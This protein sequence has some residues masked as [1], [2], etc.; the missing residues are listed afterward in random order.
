MDADAEQLNRPA[1]LGSLENPRFFAAPKEM[2]EW[3]EAS[4]HA[5]DDQWVGYW[6][7][8]SGLPSVT[9]PESVDVALCF[10]WIDGLRK[11][12]DEKSYKIRFTPRRPGS[13]WSARNIARMKELKRAGLVTEAGLAV[14]RARNAANQKK[15]SYEQPAVALPTEYER[16][17]RAEP[18]AWRWFRKARPSYRKQVAWWVV[19]AKREDTRLRR[20]ETLIESCA[21]GEVVPA[22]RWS[23][24]RASAGTGE[25]GPE[26][27]SRAPNR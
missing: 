8:D 10:G 1:P 11:S 4:H 7:K 17:I 3:L 22:M 25:P 21:K 13:H 5:A 12:I 27:A 2:R 9:W 24:K 20:L 23:A 14:Y 6:K 18:R 16:R 26:A 15:A 19:S